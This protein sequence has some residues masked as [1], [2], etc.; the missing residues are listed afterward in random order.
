MSTH[1]AEIGTEIFNVDDHSEFLSAMQIT[2]DL[3]KL[4]TTGEGNN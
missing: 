1:M 2:N 3:S 4:V